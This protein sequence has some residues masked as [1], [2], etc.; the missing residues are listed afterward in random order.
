MKNIL[1]VLL[2]TTTLVRSQGFEG[3]INWKMTMEITDP[4]VKAQMEEAQQKMNDPAQQAQMKEM[5]ERMNDP[6]MK[7][8]MEANPQMKAQMEKMLKM[9]QGGGDMTSL[10]PTGYS[11]KIKNKNSLISMQ[12]G[13]MANTDILFLSEKNT[14]YKIDRESK[15]YSTLP[16]SKSEDQATKMETKVTKTSETAKILG[17]TCIKYIVDITTEGGHAMQQFFWTT[18]AIKD[19]D[20]KSMA[21][22]RMSNSKQRMYFDKVDGVPLK[23]EMSM[24]QG[25]MIM[26]VTELKKMSLPASD[27]AIPAGF[28]EV[29]NT[30]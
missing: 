10:I 23:V 24:P 28:K 5:E 8:M 21:N 3:V 9:A 4:K 2:L 12:G 15:T 26:E 22:D 1:F 13:M 17:Y 16:Q 27:F 30:F 14:T 19:I 18:T 6:Q 29:P 7:A 11:I 20:F 25:N